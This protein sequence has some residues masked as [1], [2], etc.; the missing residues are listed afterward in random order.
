MLI[1]VFDC[2]NCEV[3]RRIHMKLIGSILLLV[4]MAG[5]ATAGAVAPEIDG[6]SAYAAITL[7][8]GALLVLRSRRKN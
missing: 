8:S 7:L 2:R 1:S 6:N 5:F 4:G 3:I